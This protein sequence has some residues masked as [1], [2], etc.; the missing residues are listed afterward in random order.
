VK[1]GGIELHG[2]QPIAGG[3][4]ADAYRGTAPDG[5]AVFAKTR[6]GAPEG[7]FEAEAAGLQ[8]LRDSRTVRVPDVVGVGTDGL[9]LRWVD[10]G[11]PTVVAAADF[12]ESLARLHATTASAYGAERDGFIGALPLDNTFGDDWPRF[13]VER[14]LQPYVSALSADDRRHLDEVCAAIDE[15]AGPTGSP[16]LLHGDLWSG[17]LLWAAEGGVWLVDAAAA[18]WGHPETDLAMLALFGAPHLDVILSAYQAVTPLPEGWRARLSLHQLHP[19]LVHAAMFGGG[20][21]ARAG[22]AALDALS[23]G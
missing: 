6:T 10:A 21:G 18:H 15:L 7:F 4:V 17:N 2:V 8:R 11:E 19:L 12:G 23:A 16:A 5:S 3:D 20:W 9:V 14:R 13:Y 22:A 1:I